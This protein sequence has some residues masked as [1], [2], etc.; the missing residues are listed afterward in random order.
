M[1]ILDAAVS[2][3]TVLHYILSTPIYIHER[4]GIL[5]YTSHYNTGYDLFKGPL[6][7]IVPIV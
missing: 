3:S 6:Y 5:K 1:V 7:W 2:G 4:D